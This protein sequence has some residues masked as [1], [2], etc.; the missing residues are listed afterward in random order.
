MSHPI[1]FLSDLGVRDETVGVCHAVMAGIAPEARV[2]DIGHGVPP[3]DVRAGALTLLQALPYLPH[4]AVV[5]AVVDP[6]SGTDRT[7]LV[8]R[9]AADRW[10][11]GPDN[12]LLSL[13]W[14]AD[15]GVAEAVAIAERAVT[16]A[17]IS[18]VLHVRD[19]FAPAAAN[20]AIGTPIG[21]FGPAV[22]GAG[23]VRLTLP[24]PEIAV[25]RLSG[26]VLDIDRFGNVRLNVRAADLAAARLDPDA[27]VEVAS[28][29]ASTRCQPV[30]TYSEVPSGGCGLIED[31]WGWIAI[32]RFESSAAAL[33]GVRIGD[34]IWITSAD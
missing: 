23:L 26:E 6:G 21:R 9:T 28:V 15:G 31:A 29:S 7:A 30:R 27:P 16:L 2:I 17:T 12:G 20:L 14:E 19:V 5:L 32:V 24:V 22:D 33:L 1:A 10:L 18:P 11:V 8:V 25:R 13:A 3:T 34:P 4:D